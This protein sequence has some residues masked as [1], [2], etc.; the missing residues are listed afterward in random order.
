MSSLSTDE[1]IALLD[2]EIASLKVV[3]ALLD[4]ILRHAEWGSKR[5]GHDG[6]KVRACPV[7][8]GVDPSDRM[9]FLF[10]QEVHGHR[11]NCQLKKC[12]EQNYSSKE[13]SPRGA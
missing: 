7:C 4:R 12:L 9:S 6:Q 2:R 3:I 10:I 13:K 8:Q 1:R 5:I 11:D